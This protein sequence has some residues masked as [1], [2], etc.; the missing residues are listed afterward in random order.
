MDINE[1]K[2]QE[3]RA[4]IF[5]INVSNH[6]FNGKYEFP[7]LNLKWMDHEVKIQCP[8][9]GEISITPED[10]LKYGCL[11]CHELESSNS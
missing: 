10:H 2:E 1:F 3:K 6:I 9:H 11:L 8:V 5:F 7:N 4:Q